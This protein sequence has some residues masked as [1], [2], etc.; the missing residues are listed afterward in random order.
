[1]QSHDTTTRC[2]RG[3][4]VP[5]AHG[6]ACEEPECSGCLPRLA[7]VGLVVCR[8]C[9]STARTTLRDLP[10]LWADLALRA[11]TSGISRYGGAG[12]D[13]AQPIGD[14]PRQART[15]I[16]G[17]LVEWAQT[18]A[19]GRDVTVPREDDVAAGTRRVVAHHRGLA[20]QARTLAYLCSQPAVDG[21]PPDPAGVRAARAEEKRHLQA[22][23]VAQEDRETGRDVLVALADH[24]DRHLAWL[25]AGE[26]AEQLLHDLAAVQAEARR[27]AN[28]AR[29]D[30]LRIL[31]SCGD[32]VPVDTDQIMECRGCGRWGVLSWWIEHAAPET[33]DT[34]RLSALPEWLLT[35][36]IVVTIRQLRRLA[37]DERITPVDGGGSGRRRLFDPLAVAAVVGPLAARA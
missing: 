32:R 24:I 34:M 4:T 11:S 2:V 7:E 19:A 9:E 25:L 13:P 16:R 33:P 28:R 35:R 36:G 15:W 20:A 18:V 10:G 23:A 14:E 30:R 29:P 21:T 5:A 1:M 26:H 17:V 37:D 8:R 12:S 6:P 31:C 3:C 22:A 27:W